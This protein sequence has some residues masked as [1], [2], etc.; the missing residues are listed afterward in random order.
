M[1]NTFNN[2][3]VKIFLIVIGFIIIGILLRFFII[4]NTVF[5]KETIKKPII[6]TSFSV[7]SDITKEIT[8]DTVKIKTIVGVDQDP[9]MYQPVPNDLKL[10]T[11][12]RM[13]IL[14]G[15]GLEGWS[16]GIISSTK[17]KKPIVNASKSCINKARVML[18]A[19]NGE[20]V[21]DPHLWHDVSCII[22]YVEVITKEL[23]KEF[24]ENKDLYTE[25]SKKYINKLNNL[26]QWCIEKFNSL[27]NKHVVTTHDAFYYYG[28]RYGVKFY[29]PIGVSTESQASAKDVARIIEIIKKYK[30]KS[31]FIEQNTN[32]NIIKQIVN[33]IKN[34]DLSGVLFSDSLSKSG[35]PADTY[36]KMIKHNTITI[37]NSIES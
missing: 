20:T 14:N 17:Y 29:S 24:P 28:A 11:R 12:S 5:F 3:R 9:H 6:V 25:N 33:E 4:P 30:I 22:K 35:G 13:F 36:I 34:A 10:I 7:I 1:V 15:M 16:N 19:S 21:Y 2:H 23:I 18:I 8:G 37:I 26:D 32:G 27:K 31:I